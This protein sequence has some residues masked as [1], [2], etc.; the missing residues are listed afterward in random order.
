MPTTASPRAVLAR[1]LS[2]TAIALAAFALDARAIPIAGTDATETK[3]DTIA[4]CDGI[5][6]KA[7]ADCKNTADYSTTSLK[8]DDAS[9]KKAFDGWNAKNAADKKWNLK[10]GGAAPGGKLEI[11]QFDADARRT[12]GELLIKI[13][14]KYDG[15]DKGDFK[16]SQGLETNFTTDPRAAVPAYF[17]M[18]V[19][20]AAGCD[21][22]VLLTQCPPLYPFQYADRSF[23]DGPRAPWP[24]GIFHAWAFLSK[25]DPTTRTLTIYEGVKYGF[26]LSVGRMVPEP[27]TWMFAIVAVAVVGWRMRN[28][29]Q[30]A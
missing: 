6:G 27:E 17:D 22:S 12:V 9:F 1:L 21:D 19:G 4:F 30:S 25:S 15:A 2:A 29:A 18:D 3:I 28:R 5:D 7:Y 16:W 13:E 10:D 11:S 23:F 8:G 20:T 26:D 24:E 14:W